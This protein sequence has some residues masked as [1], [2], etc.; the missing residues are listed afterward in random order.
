M[1]WALEIAWEQTGRGGAG[2]GRLAA[3]W[4]SP[5]GLVDESR[6][7]GPAP[8]TQRS[9]G[10]DVGELRVRGLLP[11]EDSRWDAF[12]TRHAQGT[13]FHLS[14]WRRCVADVFHH[15]AHYL[16]VEQGRRWL[17]VLPLFLVKNLQ[18]RPPFVGRNLVSVPYGVYGGVL[19]ESPHAQQAL[20][21]RATELGRQ[22][23][24]G[25]VELR[26][27]E[28]R[29]GVR[30]NSHLYVTFRCPLPDSP[31]KV[32]AEIPKK[33]RAEVR[34]ACRAPGG[35]RVGAG[36]SVVT[37]CQTYHVVDLFAG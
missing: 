32:L 24:A 30:T 34:R 17:G 9:G 23:D 6:G 35:E 33:A 28:E 5:V 3:A 36:L 29:P 2:P 19:A 13:F 18:L 14:G 1:S 22:F 12:V 15:E 16:V 8:S 31:D 27:L 37:V 26:H 21:D 4:P 10:V 25:F 7:F 20:L 11:G